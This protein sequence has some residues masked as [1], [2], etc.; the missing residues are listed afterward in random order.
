[1]IAMTKFQASPRGLW[2]TLFIAFTLGAQALPGLAQD[3]AETSV[4]PDSVITAEEPVPAATAPDTAAIAEALVAT[5][6]GRPWAVL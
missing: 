6:V 4:E 2:I 3:Q 5:A 1:M